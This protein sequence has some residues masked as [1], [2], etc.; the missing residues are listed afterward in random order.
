M[1][2]GNIG[3]GFN[4]GGVNGAGAGNG[5]QWGGGDQLLAGFGRQGAEGANGCLRHAQQMNGPE[6]LQQL[7]QQLLMMLA[8]ITLLQQLMEQSG[9]GGDSFTR[10]PGGP[11]G[12]CGGGGPG[13]PGG[14]GGPD[15]PGGHSGCPNVRPPGEQPT[16]EGKENG[17]LAQHG[18]Y[19]N[20]GDGKYKITQGEYAGYTCESRGGGK[21]DVF[22]PSGKPVGVF[23]SPGGQ[24]KI[25]SPLTFDLN[26]D[27]K[28]STTGTRGGRRFDIDGDGRQDQ[29]AWAGKG[30]GVLTFDRNGDGVA[31]ADGRELFG[32]NTDVDGDGRADGHANGFDALRA[33][34][35]RHLGR[36]AVADGKLDA[37]EI[38]ALED[39]TGLR[40]NV[41]GQSKRLSELGI[42]EL[43]L[44]YREAGR[45]ADANGNEHRQLGRFT[46]NGQ[47]QQVN[48]VWFKYE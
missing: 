43:G 18:G 7:Q 30:D 47:S 22:D 20:C 41:D 45:N 1:G 3:V 23:N 46:M 35:E 19:E 13:G 21:F 34:A 14:S 48:D 9:L 27:G 37:K 12:G 28:V 44:G 33:L 10:G 11:G 42:T 15:R 2:Y 40:M 16:I 26:G 6:A 38:K 32:N 5:F 24:D 4:N 31:G 29:T 39:K 17:W 36:E 25:A 8:L